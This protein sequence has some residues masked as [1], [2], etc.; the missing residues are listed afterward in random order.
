MDPVLEALAKKATFQR[1]C[2]DGT[3]AGDR[4]NT[5]LCFLC[6]K[7]FFF[8][9][10]FFPHCC[11]AGARRAAG[12]QPMDRLVFQLHFGFCIKGKTSGPPGVPHLFA[13]FSSSP[14]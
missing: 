1:P 9:Y 2:A 10:F 3:G 5:P 12:P 6:I 8:F 7:T 11:A 14:V 4:P 13:F